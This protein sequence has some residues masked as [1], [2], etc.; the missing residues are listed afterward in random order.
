MN[1]HIELVKRWLANPKSVTVEEL[2]ANSDAAA[3]RTAVYAANAARDAA[4]AA[5]AAEAAFW[6]KRYKGMTDE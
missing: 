5:T 1:K 4:R 3:A 2:K 6:V